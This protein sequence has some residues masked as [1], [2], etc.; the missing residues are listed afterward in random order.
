MS[1][2][3]WIPAFDGRGRHLDMV[4]GDRLFPK[5]SFFP[6]ATAVIY[7]IGGKVYGRWLDT[8]EDLGEFSQLADAVERVY[9]EK[10]WNVCILLAPGPYKVGKTVVMKGGVLKGCGRSTALFAEVDVTLIHVQ[11]VNPVYHVAL[12]DVYVSPRAPTP[13]KP[14]V[15]IEGKDYSG[16]STQKMLRNVFIDRVPLDF[17]GVGL[18]VRA[19]TDE[20][21]VVWSH[22]ENL[23]FYGFDTGILLNVAA[24]RGYINSNMFTHTLIRTCR[25]GLKTTGASDPSFGI[26]VNRFYHFNFQG[27]FNPN[28][29]TAIDLSNPDV[30]FYNNSFINCTVTDLPSGAKALKLGPS[31]H[32][33]TFIDFYCFPA[34]IDWGGHGNMM[35]Q[36]SFPYQRF[37]TSS[38]EQSTTS[39]AYVDTDTALTV[40]SFGLNRMLARASLQLRS[41]TEGTAVYARLTILDPAGNPLASQEASTTSSTYSTFTLTAAADLFANGA[42][43][44]KLQYRT[45][46]ST[47]AAYIKDKVLELKLV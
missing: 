43:Q 17:K 37:K 44:V 31:C 27:D 39:T 15:L 25:Y 11:P 40:N 36:H 28:V 35:Y 8:G 21:G 3:V 42:H 12:E 1:S 13:T 18:E 41:A 23:T 2:E 14:A 46:S 19:P 24:S 26:R 45:S 16:T 47:A 29:S 32:M 10:G 9:S 5:P 6:A 7:T 34:L 33:N 22:F 30:Y 38:A 20:Q 4:K